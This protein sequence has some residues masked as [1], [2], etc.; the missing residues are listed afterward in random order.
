MEENMSK[1]N[2][3]VDRKI[4]PPVYDNDPGQLTKYISRDSYYDFYERVNSDVKLQDK[5][6]T[7]IKS[8]DLSPQQKDK[9][10]FYI[11][12]RELTPEIPG[13]QTILMSKE[14]DYLIVGIHQTCNDNAGKFLIGY[15]SQD[16]IL[17]QSS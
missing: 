7:T 6:R 15:I 1:A 3:N 17:D 14:E 4:I 8:S 13:Y 10:S 9:I 2:Q 5:L 11:Y 16:N 12:A